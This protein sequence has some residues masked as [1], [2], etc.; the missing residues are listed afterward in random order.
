MS[1]RVEGVGGN[2]EVPSLS[3]LG[4]RVFSWTPMWGSAWA[5]ACTE[6]EGGSRRKHGFLR[7]TE[8][9]AREAAA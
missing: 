5:A 7:A 8:P 2:R 3:I 1:G 6:E 4:P 9:Q